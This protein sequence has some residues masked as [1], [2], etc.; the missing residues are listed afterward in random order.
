MRKAPKR[1]ARTTAAV[2]ENP[3]DQ[4]EGVTG[5]ELTLDV[6]VERAVLRMV[7]FE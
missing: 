7:P 1:P 4:G 2:P 3:V 6:V 5:R